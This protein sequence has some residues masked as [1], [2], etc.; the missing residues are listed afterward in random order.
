MKRMQRRVSQAQS[1][2]T[3]K[4]RALTSPI[5]IDIPTE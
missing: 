2:D 3:G 1:D 4:K 5:Q